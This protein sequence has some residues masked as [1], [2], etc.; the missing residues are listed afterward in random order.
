MKKVILFYSLLCLFAF[1]Y[2]Q[3]NQKALVKFLEKDFSFVPSGEVY[4]GEIKGA[5]QSFYISKSEITNVQYRQFINDL[6]LN[7]RLDDLKIALPDTNAWVLHVRSAEK[8]KEHYFSHPAYDH[9]PVVNVSYE[10]AQLYCKWYYEKVAKQ[11]EGLN[12]NPFRLPYKAEFIRACRG[13][14]HYQQYAWN[15]SELTKSDDGSVLC[16]FTSLG[17]ENIHYNLEKKTYEIILIDK[18]STLVGKEKYTNA[19]VTA[20]SKSYWPNVFGLY[21]LNGNVAEMINE[22][23]QAIG[24]SWRSPGYDVRNESVQHYTSPQPTI[25]FRMVMTYPGKL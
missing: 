7:N 4:V 15:G 11:F 19:D 13:D 22:K 1:R 14:N 18:S 12:V 9:Y 10:G 25:G 20:P 5:V 23:G 6:R 8:Y 2:S 21:N 17:S 16:N 3:Q 24:G